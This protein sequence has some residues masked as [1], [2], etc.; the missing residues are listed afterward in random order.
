LT[1][2]RL[3]IQ[4]YENKSL[5]QSLVNA[6]V[7]AVLRCLSGLQELDDI[8]DG[9]WL[10]LSLNTIGGFWHRIWCAW[11]D[12]DEFCLSR[13]KL[14]CSRQ[15]LQG[16]L[17]ALHSYVSFAIHHSPPPLTIILFHNKYKVSNGWNLE[18][19]CVRASNHFLGFMTGI[20]NVSLPCTTLN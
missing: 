13:K 14:S 19:N 15:S 10:D 16:L 18:T 4:L 17:M 11:W 1:L 7:P 9:T 8:I 6:I 3:A 5:S 2:T 12:G 20:A